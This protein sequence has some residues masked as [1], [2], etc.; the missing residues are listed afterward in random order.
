MP[1]GNGN[2]SGDNAHSRGNISEKKTNIQNVA[3]AI[4]DLLY[5]EAIKVKDVREQKINKAI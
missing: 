4:E 1:A 5:L 2:I 3:S